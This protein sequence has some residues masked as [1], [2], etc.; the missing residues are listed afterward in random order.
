MGLLVC[1]CE[2]I[3]HSVLETFDHC[4]QHVCGSICH[5]ACRVSSE[6]QRHLLVA[7]VGDRGVEGTCL[8]AGGV[9]GAVLVLELRLDAGV[10]VLDLLQLFAV[11]GPAVG[12]VVVIAVEVID[13]SLEECRIAAEQDGTLTAEVVG[14]DHRIGDDV[15]EVAGECIVQFRTIDDLTLDGFVLD[16]GELRGGFGG[17]KLSGL[18]HDN[19]HWGISTPRSTPLV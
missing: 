5:A 11:A 3:A 10:G 13:H 7:T 15:G 14:S 9:E 8:V 6:Y 18:R 12:R 16:G 1:P 19:L 2:V 17:A 4:F